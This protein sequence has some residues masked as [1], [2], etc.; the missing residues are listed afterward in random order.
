M[1][2]EY[3]RLKPVGEA[4]KLCLDHGDMYLMNGKAAGSD[5]K[6]SSIST[7]RHRAGDD[8][9]LKRNDKAI[10]QKVSRK[11]KKMHIKQ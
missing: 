9:F 3:M 2:Q 6:K 8:Q 1:W 5:W 7:F 10:E 4:T 11:R